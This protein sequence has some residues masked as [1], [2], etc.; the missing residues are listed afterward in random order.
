M[1]QRVAVF[2]GGK[3]GEALL[4]GLLR[5]GRPADTMVV[6]E[7]HPERALE[8]RERY[9][10]AT[11]SNIEAVKLADMLVLAVKPQDMAAL[12]T[13]IGQD[14]RPDQLVVSVA[15]GIP[16]AFLERHLADGVPVV[17]VMTNTAVFVDAAMSAIS[18]GSHATAEHLRVA[19]ALL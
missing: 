19:E 2:G 13:E 12:L 11:P 15:A 8:L 3:M 17:R 9:G 5:A 18:A 4:S 16:T 1:V 10:V 14:V 6:T 7:R